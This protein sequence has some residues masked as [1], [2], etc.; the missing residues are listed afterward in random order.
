MNLDIESSQVINDEINGK[1]I[2]LVS[3]FSGNARAFERTVNDQVL[4]FNYVDRR[5]I[6]LQ[7]ESEW[8]YEVMA[9]SGPLEGA[10]LTRMEI[11]PGFWFEWV[12]FHPSTD[13][14]GDGRN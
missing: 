9:V 14:F 12:A 7:T 1:S 4:E 2:L 6:D 10:D 5:L 11:D 8:S 3:Q 13:V